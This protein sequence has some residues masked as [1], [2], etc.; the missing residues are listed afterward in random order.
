MFIPDIIFLAAN[1]ISS[2][3][4]T[5]SPLFTGQKA[6]LKPKKVDDKR[7]CVVAKKEQ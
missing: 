2:N 5:D 7:R 4:L 6:P 1:N 3:A